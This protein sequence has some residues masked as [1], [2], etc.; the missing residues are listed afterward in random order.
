[1]IVMDKRINIEITD[2]YGNPVVSLFI[3]TAC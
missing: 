3:R 2:D 1:M